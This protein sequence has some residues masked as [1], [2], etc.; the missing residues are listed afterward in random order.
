MSETDHRTEPHVSTEE[1]RAALAP[2][3]ETRR[4]P[5][6]VTEQGE[7]ADDEIAR[8]RDALEAAHADKH[9]LHTEL[10]LSRK[11]IDSARAD[12]IELRAALDAARGDAAELRSELATAK[13]DLRERR[14]ALEKLAD[15]GLFKRRKLVREYR[16]RGLI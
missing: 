16:T 1:L 7:H 11:A 4:N 5:V 13:A 9:E 6:L 8:L 12:A 10:D 3:G 15:A 14:T 2:R